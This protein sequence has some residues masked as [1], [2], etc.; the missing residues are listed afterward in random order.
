MNR[1]KINICAFCALALFYMISVTESYAATDRAQQAG[2]IPHKALYDIR[3]KSKKS[4]SKVSNIHGKMMYKWQP[5]CDSWLTDYQFDMVYEYIET[6]SVHIKSDF[7]SHESFDG[8]TFNF[9]SSRKAADVI[10]DEIQGSIADAD[11]NTPAKA[12]YKKPT[13]ME[14]DLPENTVYPMAHTLGVLNSIK[15]NKMFY[16]VPLFDGSDENGP[17]DVNTFIGKGDKYIIP[18]DAKEHIDSG[19]INTKA[20]NVRIAF[21]PLNQYNVL[22]DYEMTL[23]FHE[24]GV[25]SD[26]VIDYDDFSVS[27]KLIAVEPLESLCTNTTDKK[28]NNQ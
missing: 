10:L 18:E 16:N 27:Q 6:P 9:V 13:P 12:I 3:M 8:K 17:V 26:V 28:T 24:N 22:S 7:S 14:F 19:L 2:L 21:F 5:S 20:W 1:W 23:L 11:K 25:I 15:E 4:N